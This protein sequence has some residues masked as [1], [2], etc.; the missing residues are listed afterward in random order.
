M[1]LRAAALVCVFVLAAGTASAQETRAAIE[2][3]NKEFAAAFAKHDAT[4]VASFYTAN[5]EAFPPNA[6]VIRGRAGIAKMWQGVFAAGIAT[7]ELKTTE[8]HA[9]GPIAFEVGS[10]AMKLKNGT[11]ADR[12]KY[13]VVWMKED[14]KW[15][16]HRDIWNTDLPAPAPPAKQ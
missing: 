12:G 8:V 1:H 14:G 2:A 9:Q 10:Y 15:K 4:G 3:V 5:A 13:V 11:V 7:A 16:L 6:A